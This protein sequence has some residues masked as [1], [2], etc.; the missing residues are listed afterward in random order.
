[1]TA[2]S[3]TGMLPGPETICISKF[4]LRRIRALERALMLEN[5]VR[6]S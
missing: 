1:M 2:A 4:I 6:L 5:Q 3:E